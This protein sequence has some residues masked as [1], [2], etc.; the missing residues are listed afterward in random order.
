MTRSKQFAF[1]GINIRVH[2]KHEPTEYI[3][4]WKRLF[5]MKAVHTH[6]AYG[7]MI[8]EVNLE[9][10][11]SSDGLIRGYFYSF[12]QIDPT[13]QWFNVTEHRPAEPE[14]VSQVAIPEGLKPNLKMVPYIFD[15]KQHQLF[16]ITDDQDS[17]ASP[18]MVKKLL[19]KM[20][21]RTTIIERFAAIDLTV[22][23][24]K[25]KIE[26]ILSWPVIR[27]LELTLE[28]TNPS[29]YDDEVEVFGRFHEMGIQREERVYVKAKGASSIKPDKSLIRVAKIAADNGEVS[30]SGVNS[31]GKSD[32]AKSTSFPMVARERY[33]P[34]VQTLF[35]AFMQ[36]VREKYAKR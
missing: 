11:R 28:R 1:S 32:S 10:Y 16:F 24:D 20:C 9:D 35:E 8:G 2:S 33:F 23:T 7:I 14:E 21:A 27:R 19:D 4:L 26:K 13:Q 3:E 5:R 25:A 29:D 12:I 18:A 15:V 34:A 22:L 17:G 36:A 31:Q 30:V 6:G